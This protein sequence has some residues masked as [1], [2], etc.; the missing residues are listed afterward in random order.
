MAGPG[1]DSTKATTVVGFDNTGKVFKST[2]HVGHAHNREG[3]NC[4]YCHSIE[5]VRMLSLDNDDGGVYTLA[6]PYLTAGSQRVTHCTIPKMV[7]TPR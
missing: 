5:T 6:K 4:A 2:L 3:V 1:Y 7:K